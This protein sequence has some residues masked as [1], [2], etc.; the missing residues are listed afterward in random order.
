MLNEFSSEFLD[1]LEQQREAERRKK[2]YTEA[3]LNISA[4]Y[5]FTAEERNNLYIVRHRFQEERDK[6]EAIRREH[7]WITIRERSY[8]DRA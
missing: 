8:D 1:W 7:R 5:G 3:E 2:P 6:G 4:R